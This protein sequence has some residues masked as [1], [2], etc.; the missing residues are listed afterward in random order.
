[1]C[2]APGVYLV[3]EYL[4]QQRFQFSPGQSH[5]LRQF[6]ISA[7]ILSPP[8]QV[9]FGSPQGLTHAHTRV[10]TRRNIAISLHS[11][12]ATHSVCLDP[13]K[14][15]FGSFIIF[16][17][18]KKQKN[19]C[20]A[21]LKKH[22]EDGI[23]TALCDSV[24]LLS[25]FVW[26]FSPSTRVALFLFP[27]HNAR[28]LFVYSMCST[29]YFSLKSLFPA[30]H[31]T[32]HY[33]FPCARSLLHDFIARAEPSAIFSLKRAEELVA[34]MIFLTSLCLRARQACFTRA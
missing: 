4:A 33:F 21:L 5:Q 19:I 16:R 13:N 23:K 22:F 31:G 18:E 28:A 25:S 27:R 8:F 9:T 20:N 11:D 17:E 1:M 12:F 15:Q 7:G 34:R 14:N 2:D 32:L 26:L 6:K 30:K 3:T 24:I 29:V 10:L